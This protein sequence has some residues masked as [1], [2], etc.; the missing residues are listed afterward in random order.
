MFRRKNSA[1][2]AAR[3]ASET[4]SELAGSLTEVQSL[5][6]SAE[7]S[8]ARAAKAAEQ[9]EAKAIAAAAKEQAK[10]DKAAG[11]A[12]EAERKAQRKQLKE[13]TALQRKQAKTARKATEEAAKPTRAEKK[14]LKAEEKMAKE[15]AKHPQTLFERATDPK[16]AKRALSVAKII[17]PVVAPLALRAATG[18]RDYLDNRRAVK[19]GVPI[20][21][22]GA[23]KGPT[24]A[25]E[26]RLDG[27]RSAI[28]D[29]RSRHSGD[30][31]VTRFAEV[32]NG[33]I[34]DL[35]AAVRASVTM[36]AGR[37]RNTLSAV[38]AELNQ[39]DADLMSHLVNR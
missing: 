13:M 29:L 2:S 22:V 17:G 38:T 32:A 12:A 4:L 34:T 39:I 7:K 24:G 14:T 10:A 37:R 11:K 26:A 21:E 28:N 20:N 9:T 36:P 5:R 25:V 16:S 15:L 30:L 3:R 31:Q 1:K 8:A 23:Y 6:K 19:L 18:T 27:L 35:T 33:R